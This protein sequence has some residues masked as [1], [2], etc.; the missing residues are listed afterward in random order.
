MQCLKSQRD[1]DTQA[2][3]KSTRINKTFNLNGGKDMSEE[4]PEFEA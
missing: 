3:T 1:Y 2:M 4:F